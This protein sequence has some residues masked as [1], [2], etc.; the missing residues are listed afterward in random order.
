MVIYFV[1]MLLF[2]EALNIRDF[3]ATDFFLIA[4][5]NIFVACRQIGRCATR[6]S[7]HPAEHKRHY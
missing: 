7:A 4:G 6:A 3:N 2:G 5:L 1:E